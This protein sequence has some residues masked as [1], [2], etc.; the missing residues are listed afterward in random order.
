MISTRSMELVRA[1][2]L[3]PEVLAGGVDGDVW[4]W[5][6]E[7]LAAAAGDAPPGR[8]PDAEQAAVVS[9]CT[10]HRAPGLARDGAA[11]PRG[12]AAGRPDGAGHRAR[13]RRRR[14]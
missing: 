10:R 8:L 7:T 9:P 13:R 12:I 4:L 3:E 14:S 11:P 5:E 2:R 1:W 6:C